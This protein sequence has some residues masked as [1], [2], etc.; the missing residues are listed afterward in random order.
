MNDPESFAV[1]KQGPGKCLQLTNDA[2]TAEV[3]MDNSRSDPS[4]ASADQLGIRVMRA[5][6]STCPED[7]SKQMSFTVDI[8]CN[9]DA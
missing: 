4:N 2:A 1:E 8:W 5:G 9:P 3:I 6:G 7:S